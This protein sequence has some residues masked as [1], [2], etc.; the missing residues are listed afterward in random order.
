[1]HLF[2]NP[3]KALNYA[4]FDQKGLQNGGQKWSWDHQKSIKSHI[5]KTNK[6]HEKKHKQRCPT[7]RSHMQSAHASAVQ[8][9]F[10]VLG[11]R[12]KNN[13]KEQQNES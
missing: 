6:K 12:L 5:A 10:S 4:V 8:T 11:F 13:K 9:Q 7:G 2:L 1:M 3:Q